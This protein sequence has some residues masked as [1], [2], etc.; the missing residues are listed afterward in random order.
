MKYTAA[1]LA[2]SSV[3]CVSCNREKRISDV[4]PAVAASVEGARESELQ[5]GVPL[6]SPDVKNPFEGNYDAMNQG[7][8]LFSQFNC[9][10]CHSPGGGGGIGPPLIDDQWIYGDNPA[11]IYETI[12]KGRPNGMPSFGG[13]IPS[14]QI[15]Q[16]V[17][18]VRSMS[19]A[20][21]SANGEK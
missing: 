5:P 6:P 10:G 17:T 4:T 15:W 9:A 7:G 13:K 18:Y 8:R 21:A 12:I 19:S 11:N 1:V 16:L 2:M 14:Y 3:V 20:A